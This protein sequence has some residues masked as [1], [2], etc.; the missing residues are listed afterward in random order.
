MQPVFYSVAVRQ[1]LNPPPRI[2]RMHATHEEGTMTRG[3]LLAA[4]AAVSLVA[5]G[6]SGGSAGD[7]PEATFEAAKKVA[8]DRDYRGMVDMMAPSQLAVMEKQWKA[9]MQ[10]EGAAMMAT[11]LG[12]SKEEVEKMS[13]KDYM[14]AMM[15]KQAETD[16][17]S[18]DLMEDAAI[19]DKK[20]EGDRCTLTV[21][22]KDGEQDTVKLVRED[23]RWYLAG[24]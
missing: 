9:G 15:E 22:K 12:K 13:F 16:A 19:V 11:M 24:N 3:L 7:T 17:E 4:L 2:P 6:G 18:V 10:G 1:C 21:K 23:G 14:V 5:C 20:V 8:A